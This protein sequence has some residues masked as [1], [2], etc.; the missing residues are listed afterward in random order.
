VLAAE[1]IPYGVACLFF[2]PCRRL[3]FLA[4]KEISDTYSQAYAPV[5]PAATNP[6]ANT[7]QS[8]GIE[9]SYSRDEHVSSGMFDTR[10]TRQLHRVARGSRIF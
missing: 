7:W 4:L 3:N 8:E 6:G 1:L 9:Q 10:K 5:N 2:H